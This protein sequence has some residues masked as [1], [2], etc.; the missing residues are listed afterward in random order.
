M[1]ESV[2][3]KDGFDGAKEYSHPSFGSVSI[4]K[5]SC[6]NKAMFG[7]S[8]KHDNYITLKIK[9][10]HLYRNHFEDKHSNS[11]EK[12]I[13]EI[14]LSPLQFSEMLT[15]MNYGEGVPCTIEHRID[16][17]NCKYIPYPDEMA[18]KDKLK[19]FLDETGDVTKD[20]QRFIKPHLEKVINNLDTNKSLG[21][22]A[23]KELLKDLNIV[24]DHLGSNSKFFMEQFTRYMEGTVVEA[25]ATIDSHVDTIVRQTGLEAIKA[26]RLMID[27][28]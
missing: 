6:G 15:T 2:Q 13:V 19:E 14:A 8:I 9:Q 5:V 12:T 26:N 27:K 20:L 11:G 28:T 18:H 7:S 23:Q 21:K 16:Y 17:N 3:K 24:F 10:S 25:K 4:S 22:T 1:K